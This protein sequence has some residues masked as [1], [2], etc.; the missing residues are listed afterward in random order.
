MAASATARQFASA[1][2]EYCCVLK[3]LGLH[4]DQDRLLARVARDASER[5]RLKRILYDHSQG[6]LDGEMAPVEAVDG[7]ESL[8]EALVGTIRAQVAQVSEKGV[9]GGGLA[10]LIEGLSEESKGHLADQVL[11]SGHGGVV[12]PRLMGVEEFQGLLREFA[13]TQT[14][15]RQKLIAHLQKELARRGIEMSCQTIQERFR[16][17]PAVR[18]MPYCVK[19]VFRGLGDEFRTGLVP[20][21]ELVGDRAP[22]AWLREAQEKLQFRSQSAMHKAIADASDLTYDCVHKALSGRRKAKRI[23]VGV[24]NCLHEWLRRAVAGETLEIDE[25]CRGV[26]VA[27]MCV[28]MPKLLPAFGTKEAV[29]RYVAAKTGLR[30]GSIRRY[31]QN[32]GQLKHAPLSVYRVAQ[33]AVAQV[34]AEAIARAATRPAVRKRPA[35]ARAKRKASP[36]RAVPDVGERGPSARELKE[37]MGEIAEAAEKALERWRRDRQDEELE[38]EFKELRRALIMKVRQRRSKESAAL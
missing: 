28:L 9:S 31:F 11:L 4:V 5:G 29:Y 23:Q 30:T 37:R 19:E 16:S 13:G 18:T 35:R 27:D 12:K 17:S 26:P 33:E 34:P 3:S 32:D 15:A 10:E 36:T 25:E 38:M 7:M 24:K 2:T 8:D 21:S 14:V 6:A 20:I 1:Y 22:D